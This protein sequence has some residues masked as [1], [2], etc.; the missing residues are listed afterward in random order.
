M[1]TRS[2]VDI[3]ESYAR[4][5]SDAVA[6]AVDESESGALTPGLGRAAMLLLPHLTQA[7]E[8]AKLEKARAWTLERIHELQ[9]RA[10]DAHAKVET[11][12]GDRD[13]YKIEIECRAQI[14]VLR[15]SLGQMEK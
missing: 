5:L 7:R 4:Q 15:E 6:E 1:S 3:L 11:D 8:N 10:A 13:A 12:P 9:E 14:E 2:T